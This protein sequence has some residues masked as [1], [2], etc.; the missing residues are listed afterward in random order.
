MNFLY[1]TWK[2]F[3]ELFFV[4]ELLKKI[5]PPRKKREITF[6]NDRE[7]AP[8]SLSENSIQFHLIN[9]NQEA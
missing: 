9:F 8:L 3:Y 2:Y 4:I 7:I 5:L 1:P 6:H